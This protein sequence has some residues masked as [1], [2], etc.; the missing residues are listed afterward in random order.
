MST[1]GI[2]RSARID[3]WL[4]A[5]GVVVAASERACR[6]AAAAFHAARKAEGLSAWLTPAIVSWDGWVREQWTKRN[7]AGL[8]LLNPLQEQALWTKV[9]VSS[10]ANAAFLH[11]DRLATAAQRAY[12]LL[13]DFAPEA[14]SPAARLGWSGDPA[15]FSTWLGE[16]ASKCQYDGLIS[17]SRLTGAL[18]EMLIEGELAEIQA[19]HRPP[20]LLV[21]FDRL[22]G[23]QKALL[24]AWGHSQLD[25]LVVAAGEIRCYQAPDA[26]AEL[27]ACVAW[28]RQKLTANPQA[29]L[30]VVATGLEQRRG[31]IERALRKAPNGGEPSLDFEFTLGVSLAQVGLSRSALLLLRWLFEP[32]TEAELDWLI[33]SGYS[34]VSQEEEG[35]L[36]Q[37][38]RWLRQ[39]GLERTEWTL[40]AF[41][42]L[43]GGSDK[44]GQ[45]ASRPLAAWTERMT[46]TRE[47]LQQA[48]T[49]TVQSAIAWAELVPEL[50]KVAGWPGFRQL[51]SAAY[52]AR[53]TF[54][55]VVENCATL[56]FDGSQMNWPT[57][58]ITLQ[59]AVTAKIFAAE[60]RN[61]AILVSEPVVSA[62]QLVDG[63]WFLGASEENW[64]GRAAAHPLLPF[65]LQREAKMP[66]STAQADWDLAEQATARILTSADEVVFSHPRQTTDGESRPSRLVVNAVGAPAPLPE[67]LKSSLPGRHP[68]IE[69]FEDGSKVHFPRYAIEGGAATLT[70]QSLC[71]FKAF[72]TARLNAHDW[73]RAQAGLNARQRGQLLHAVLHRVWS[74][75]GGGLASLD[76][77]RA[78]PDLTAF[79]HGIVHWTIHEKLPRGLR[80]MLPARFLVLEEQRLTKLVTAW[81]DY[82]QAR[83]PF[84][85]VETEADRE[86]TVAGLSLKLR[87]DRIDVVADGS[88]FII[89]YKTGMVGP[90]A[91]DGDRPDDVQLPLYATFAIS[92][93]V[94]GLV[95]GR[96]RPG[97]LEFYGRVRDAVGFLRP[98]LSPQTN[99]VKRPLTDSDLD[100]WRRLIEQL[101][102]DFLAG[103]A[104]VNPKDQEKIC[105]NC[106]LHAV[107]R[108]YENQY[109]AG[110]EANEE[111]DQET[112]DNDV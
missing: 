63:I 13:C 37:A 27:N 87:L 89:D 107:C 102:M 62:G 76:E 33:C 99:L 104:D 85:V 56:G 14:L 49:L 5:G 34:A 12:L 112:A 70:S 93:R 17:A 50:L 29:R 20:I 19:H 88:Q 78:L 100:A 105:A 36:A 32:L 3:G 11:P 98:D 26:P 10:R 24:Q 16:F 86:V 48:V 75:K 60:S 1:Q 43:A 67:N 77:L 72:A 31:E 64:P 91:W 61:S 30:M 101:G 7:D 21:G 39:R 9:I 54:D 23:T 69:T 51:G 66:H 8:V 110:S 15:I 81:L 65:S 71:Q 84:T 28:L 83:L 46:A 47:R 59:A 58:V 74:K 2:G 22:L 90:S 42:N 73:E 44:Q 111:D 35:A 25:E 68:L 97:D 103:R 95:F 108:I 82:E 4:A 92:E 52:Q 79:V 18:T 41:C 38:M 96:V 94:E 45:L 106:H 55:D 6:S 80:E 57:F 53:Q 109:L 40:D